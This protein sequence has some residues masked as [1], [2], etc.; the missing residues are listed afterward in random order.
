MCLKRQGAVEVAL[1][2]R[3]QLRAINL[4]V[5]REEIVGPFAQLPHVIYLSEIN[6]SSVKCGEK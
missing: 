1:V 5:R 2:L 6:Y 3:Y 4:P